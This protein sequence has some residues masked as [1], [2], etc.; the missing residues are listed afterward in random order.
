MAR[1]SS[2]PSR[3]PKKKVLA[4]PDVALVLMSTSM[5]SGAAHLHGKSAKT[6]DEREVLALLGLRLHH[7]G[8]LCREQRLSADSYR[9]Y[10]EDASPALALQS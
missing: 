3:A 10:Q 2:R 5:L 9:T 8:S 4:T 7:D 6:R 1:A